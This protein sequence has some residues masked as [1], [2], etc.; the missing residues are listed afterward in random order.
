VLIYDPLHLVIRQGPNILVWMY[1]PIN[2]FLVGI[3][4]KDRM[5]LF[6]KAATYHFKEEKTDFCVWSVLKGQ[7]RYILQ[8]IL[9]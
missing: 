9:F 4:A 6:Y 8:K 1:S 3:V 7:K 2:G 5:L